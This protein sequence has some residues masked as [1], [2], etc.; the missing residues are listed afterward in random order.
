M[1]VEK[2]AKLE[3]YDKVVWRINGTLILLTCLTVGFVCL[4]AG[5]KLVG[6]LFGQHERHDLINV[7][8][9]TK[10]Q[11]L[12]KLGYFESLPGT[13]LVLVPL[14]FEQTI[15]MP[16]YSK[17][18]H[19]NSRNFL[20]LNAKTKESYWIYKANTA[21]V[22]NTDHVYEK[23]VESEKD[24]KVVGLLIDLVEADSNH[25]GVLSPDDQRTLQYFDL[26][27]KKLVPIVGEVERSIG[28]KQ[29]DSEELVLFYSKSG[30]SF[31][32]SLSLSNL[33]VA[34]EQEVAFSQ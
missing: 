2:L 32:R 16:L 28:N 19:S 30:K 9:N 17:S 7:D 14:S 1:N 21:L 25:D 33:S 23:V 22:I 31:Y 8:Q 20:V 26:R 11:E 18:T 4:I 13:N 15:A 34:G 24:K 12:L 29:V 6:D 27:Q 10:K 3:K 5:W